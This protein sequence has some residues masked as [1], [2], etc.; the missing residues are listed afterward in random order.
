[1]TDFDPDTA[2][3]DF[4]NQSDDPIPSGGYTLQPVVGIGGSSGAIEALQSLLASV[5]PD[6]GLA[7]VVI[8]HLSRDHESTLAELLQ[9]STPMRV[10]QVQHDQQIE[11]DTVYV[12]P[13]RYALQTMDG[14]IQLADLPHERHRHVAVD[15]FFRALADTHGPHAVAVVLSGADGD[16]ASGIK[17]IKERGGLTIV[18]DPQEAGHGGMP[19][20]AIATGMVDWVLPVVEIGPRIVD[21]VG[22]EQTVRLPPEQE[23]PAAGAGRVPLDESA[24]RDV[25]NLLKT[26]TGR[27][28]SNYKRATI[29]RR[30]GRRMQVNAVEDMGAYLACLRTRHGEA[31]AL[32]QDLLITVT[33][34]FRDAECFAALETHIPELFKDKGPSDTVRVWVAACATG[35]EAYSMAMLLSDYARA[36]DAPPAIQVFASD[37]DEEAIRVA[38]EAIYPPTIEGDVSEE[39]LRRFFVREHRGYRVRRELREMVLFAAHDLLKDSP[40]SRLDL[41]SCRNLL[42]YLNRDAQ[43][44][45]LDTFHF[46]LRSDALLFLGS[47]E[48]VDDASSLFA[49]VDKRRRLFRKRPARRVT[50]PVSSGPGSLALALEQ[51]SDGAY[52]PVVAAASSFGRSAPQ[53]RP[54]AEAD[55]SRSAS[56]GELHFRLIDHLAPPSML[57]DEQQDVLHLSAG[58]GRFLLHGGG[59]PSRNLMRLI[60][61]ALRIELRAALYRAAQS[62]EAADGAPVVLDMEGEH[63]TVAVRV[64]PVPD[65][66]SGLQLVILRNV[67]EAQ[68]AALLPARFQSDAVDP[69]A[70]HL[71]QELERLKSHLRDTVE[72]Y[73][74]STEELKASN[75][76]L[77]AMNEELRSASEELETSR[78]ELQS[79]NE[80]LTTVNHELKSNV[81]ELAHANSDMHNLMDATAIATIFLDRDLRITRYTP[82]ART[83]F[84]LIPTDVGR[85][86]SDLTTELDYPAL[87]DDARRVLDRL[88]PVETEVGKAGDGW[89]L[90]RVLPYRTLDDHIA[91]VVLT[92]VDISELKQAQEALRA[93]E[94]RFGAIVN[95]AAVGVVQIDP[96]GLITYTNRFYAQMLGYNEGELRGRNLLDLVHPDDR[97][98]SRRHM[99]ELARHHR[100]LQFEKRCVCKG[101]AV[102][103]LHNSVSLLAGSQPVA[104]LLVSTD[105]S[106]RKRAEAALR[107]SEERMR[108][109]LEAA[110]EYAIFTTDPSGRITTWNPG[111]QRLLGYSESEVIGQ[112][113]DLIF[114]EADRREGAPAAEIERAV[115]D[116]RAADDRLHQRKDGSQFWASGALMPMFGAGDT[117]LGFVKI[118]RDQSAQRA[119]QDALEASNRSKDRFLAVL[120]HELRNPLAS[121]HGAALALAGE[122]LTEG[123]RRRAIEIVQRQADHMRVLLDELLDISTL[124]LGRMTL[125]LE[126]V[127]VRELV[128]AALEATR[129]ALEAA[130]HA[131]AVHLPTPDITLVCDRVR[132]SQVLANL[133]ANA[134]KYTPDGGHIEVAARLLGDGEVQFTISDDGDGMEAST[135]ES[136]FEMFSRN[137]RAQAGNK[138]GLGIGLALVRSIVD[139]H[140]G[141]VVGE[142]DGPGKG[143][144]FTVTVPVQGDPP[145]AE[146]QVAAPRT[147][148]EDSTTPGAAEAREAG[149]GRRVVIADDNA[150]AA[151]PVARMLELAG[152]SVRVAHSGEEALMLVS[153]EPVDVVIL[154][155]GLPG[156]SGYE[157]A[158]RLRSRP[159]AEA[160]V[161]VAATGWGQPDDLNKAREAG[162]D[163]HFVKP[164]DV[165]SLVSELSQRL[166]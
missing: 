10:I 130:G 82:S 57:V 3:Q 2:E 45:V 55:G 13:P 79:I 22:R 71:D 88:I 126:P 156:L 41:V 122:R 113:S 96:Q 49:A 148:A 7:Y 47:S 50:L 73:E 109:V 46:A 155:I 127:H 27:D 108:L 115:R 56:W 75:E 59:E 120:S 140:G 138:G 161:L 58:A 6:S 131:L 149:L 65:I 124:R 144:R 53:R 83:L 93:S 163:M 137:A 162:F 12:I 25:L 141:R 128:E 29:L 39:R 76:E 111:A 117:I 28:F 157:V 164:L 132:M 166:G 99:E 121:V 89:F 16:G 104:T 154:D 103:W 118:L 159:G 142:S 160:L 69:V 30:I 81:D 77:Q 150:D 66:A 42:I 21:Y 68:A 133:L 110:V 33:N 153:E 105:I 38:R 116:G 129:H 135:V 100:P 102:L 78:E 64:Q 8:L 106:E 114:V 136:M 98:V 67:V 70:E 15:L 165:R 32:L 20:S 61:P 84:K 97:E 60:H 34:F 80:E 151:W 24:L 94:D 143:A 48:S 158:T 19:R 147:P 123:E 44:R 92:F 90:V 11:P 152:Y 17:R 91:G 145:L 119:A 72:Q 35:E 139:L 23:P 5:P 107:A 31:A 51:Q 9:R 101:G 146:P 26:R 112:R 40:F 125:H 63:K 1:M 134:I 4:F 18:Q 36:L 37:L 86:L 85:P 62:G 74:A 52:G 43:T 54:P 87:S 95:E 14:Q